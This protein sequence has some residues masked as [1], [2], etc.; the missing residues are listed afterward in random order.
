MES[1]KIELVEHGHEQH[2]TLPAG[3][4]ALTSFRASRHI[5]NNTN[6]SLEA[7]FEEP[8]DDDNSS[9]AS[10]NDNPAGA[11]ILRLTV[12][13]EGASAV[14]VQNALPLYVIFQFCRDLQRALTLL[15]SSATLRA[16]LTFK[17]LTVTAKARNQVLLKGI[18]GQLRGGFWAA[19]G[20]SGESFCRRLR[21]CRTHSVQVQTRRCRT[22]WMQV[23][24]RRSPHLGAHIT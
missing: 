23:H 18:S 11:R 17:D 21:Q 2:P 24:T 20:P 10:K 12:I 7:R 16:V 22:H 6:R 5:D 15:A 14:S 3:L 1:E 9:T 4:R 19:M 13:C 8:E